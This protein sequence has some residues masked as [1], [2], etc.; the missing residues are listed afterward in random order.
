[1]RTASRTPAFEGWIGVVLAGALLA[2]LAGGIH[3]FWPKAAQPTARA[4]TPARAV[5]AP[6]M[7]EKARPVAREKATTVAASVMVDKPLP[8]SLHGT[9]E[10]GALREDERGDLVIGPEVLRL[11][12]YYLSAT[13][14]ES[15]SVLVARI[16]AAIQRSL[17]DRRAAKQA[18][19]LLD[20]YLAY[21]ADA[22]RIAPAGDDLKARLEALSGLRRQHFGDKAPALFGDEEKAVTVA[23]EQRKVRADAS[24]TPEQREQRLAQ[25]EEQLPEAVRAARE[26]A[27][28]PLR[29]AAEEEAMRAAGATEDDI[30][31]HRVATAGEEAA[32]RL[33]ELDRQRAAW[34][35]RVA[36]FRA[37]RAEIARTVADP[38]QRQAAV[39][40]LLEESFT[41]MERIRVEAADQIDGASPQP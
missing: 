41:P 40:R 28:K 24:L 6:A 20:R 4:E 39:Q 33:A 29:E 7:A 38:A 35:A 9:S 19:D 12:D 1:M 37:A 34:R 11:F 5:K 2:G 21:R 30:R 27:T 8:G 15:Q 25:L 18:R 23:I 14:E 31:A 26:A 32:D 3:R 13:G 22:K 10:D 17:G 16:E 36:A